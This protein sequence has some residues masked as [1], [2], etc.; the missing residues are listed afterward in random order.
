MF[1]I[2]ILERIIVLLISLL[3]PLKNHHL[4]WKK[5]LKTTNGPKKKGWKKP[6]SVKKQSTKTEPKLLEEGE[7][8]IGPAED[9]L[10]TGNSS[11]QT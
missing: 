9:L 4:L 2:L 7:H 3:L 11:S 10:G 6:K 8:L 1:E 5:K